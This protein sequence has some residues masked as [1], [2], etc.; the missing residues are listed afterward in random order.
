MSLEKKD[1]STL[2]GEEKI[3]YQKS[4]KRVMI[5]LISLDL[6]LVIYLVYEIFQLF[7]TK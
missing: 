6:L 4:R 5:L 1:L 3:R 7:S 2:S